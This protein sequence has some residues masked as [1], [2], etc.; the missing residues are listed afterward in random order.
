MPNGSPHS[1]GQSSQVEEVCRK[2]FRHLLQH[3]ESCRQHIATELGLSP[4]SATNYSRWLSTCGFLESRSVKGN[5][6]KRP[7]EWMWLNPSRV[8]SIAVAVTAK[9]IRAELVSADGKAVWSTERNLENRCQHELMQAL[10]AVV[11][12]CV[13]RGKKNGNPPCFAGL[14]VS[15]TIGYGI[16][17]SFDGIKEWRPC[18]PTELLPAFRQ[19]PQSEV[20]TRIQC[21]LVG[22]AHSQSRGKSMGYFE[23]DGTRLRM[24]TMHDWTVID[25]RNGTVSARL[26]Q[27][28]KRQG[29]LCYCGRRGCFVALLEHGEACREHVNGVIGHV[30]REDAIE[31]AAIEWKGE[32]EP[33]QAHFDGPTELVAVERAQDFSLGGLRMLCAEEALLQTVRTQRGEDRSSTGES[34]ETGRTHLTTSSRS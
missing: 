8:A 13:Q 17:F 1:N 21:K 7:V 14:S 30:A 2:I 9:A 28:V 6:S 26:H 23:W 18:T 10:D 25:G 11:E 19:I 20:W 32:G 27:P 29:P 5:T 22:F 33:D 4:A 24:A 16:V 15:G 31:V 12:A 34:M 3:E